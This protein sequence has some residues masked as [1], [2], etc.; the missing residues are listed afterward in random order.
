MPRT[1]STHALHTVLKLLGD[2]QE[3]AGDAGE[4]DEGNLEESRQPARSTH[5]QAR[6]L[7]ENRPGRA[8][9][10]RARERSRPRR[11]P[12]PSDAGAQARALLS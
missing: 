4:E 1:H 11:S 5:H 6:L 7:L 12:L 2:A 10:P 3:E 8:A 9:A